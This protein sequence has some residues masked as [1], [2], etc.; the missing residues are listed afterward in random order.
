[1]QV[2]ALRFVGKVNAD[3]FRK[4]TAKAIRYSAGSSKSSMARCLS[5]KLFMLIA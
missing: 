5:A 3:Y 2:L 1:M 4:T